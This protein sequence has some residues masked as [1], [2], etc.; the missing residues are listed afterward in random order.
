M[1][2]KRLVHASAFRQGPLLLTENADR[3]LS[4]L[5][6]GGPSLNAIQPCSSFQERA[7]L[8]ARSPLHNTRLR[9]PMPKPW[10]RFSVDATMLAVEAHS[11]IAMRL[12]SAAL[13]R[14]SYAENALMVTEK[15]SAFMEAAAAVAAGGSTRLSAV[16][17]STSA[18]MLGACARDNTTP[19][20]TPHSAYGSETA[21]EL[22]KPI[23]PMRR[24][25][26]CRGS[27]I[28][29]RTTALIC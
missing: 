20:V 25:G 3:M 2:G 5:Q 15:V 8:A 26:L 19:A 16:T 7:S 6:D 27:S 9:G 1:N 23:H 21:T 17:E 4:A 22:L 29:Q 24:C 28:H 18:R 11:V 10:F 13:G 12:T 14:G